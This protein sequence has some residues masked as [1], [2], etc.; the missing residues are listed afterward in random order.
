MLYYAKSAVGGF[1][2]ANYW[3]STEFSASSAWG[4]IFYN[5]FQYGDGKSGSGRVRA[6]RAF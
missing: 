2:D 6:V 5:G 3:S 4:Q 1:S